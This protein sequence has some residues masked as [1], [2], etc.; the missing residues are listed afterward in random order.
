V[1]VYK[2]ETGGLIGTPVI[3]KELKYYNNPGK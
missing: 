1:K 3:R 2:K